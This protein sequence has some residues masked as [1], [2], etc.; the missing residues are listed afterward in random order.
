MRCFFITIRLALIDLP[1]ENHLFPKDLL[2]TFE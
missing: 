2:V 1:L